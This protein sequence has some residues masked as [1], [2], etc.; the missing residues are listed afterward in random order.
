MYKIVERCVKHGIEIVK[1][2]ANRS[3]AINAMKVLVEKYKR[4]AL[5][6]GKLGFEACLIQGMGAL[7]N[8]ST[9]SLNNF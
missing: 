5:Y 9:I 3:E 2:Y 1:V 4:K 6:Y 7:L 8:K